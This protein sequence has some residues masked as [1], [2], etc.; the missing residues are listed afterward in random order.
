[1]KWALGAGL[2]L[3]HCWTILRDMAR[4]L[5]IEFPGALYQVTSRGIGQA[6]MYLNHCARE[7]FLLPWV[8]SASG[9]SGCA[10]PPA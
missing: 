2:A 10:M 5:R 4:P 6:D 9:D 7:C 8:T 1:M 3:P